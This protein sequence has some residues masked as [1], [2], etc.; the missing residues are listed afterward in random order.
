MENKYFRFIKWDKDS[1]KSNTSVA[2][3][4]TYKQERM[5]KVIRDNTYLSS[6]SLIF[7]YVLYYLGENTHLLEEIFSKEIE[8]LVEEID[9][10]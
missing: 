4:L 7:R 1:E 6:N 8:E 5:L 9:N 10:E 3:R 2:V